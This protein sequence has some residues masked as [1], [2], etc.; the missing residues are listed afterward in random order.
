MVNIGTCPEFSS[1]EID[2]TAGWWFPWSFSC[3]TDFSPTAGQGRSCS[4][5]VPKPSNDSLHAT[6][7]KDWTLA[8]KKKHEESGYLS[9]HNHGSVKNLFPSNM[10]V[11]F[12][13]G[14]FSTSNDYGSLASAIWSKIILKASLAEVP[15]TDKDFALS[16]GKK[17]LNLFG[18]WC[19]LYLLHP[20]SI[21][22]MNHHLSGSAVSLPASRRWYWSRWTSDILPYQN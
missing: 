2:H 19:H 16:W 5:T 11:S 4:C 12:H 13:L 6:S 22:W 3:H 21:I 9:S 14:W 15:S 7:H 17:P 1:K 20:T 18:S 8:K 10:I